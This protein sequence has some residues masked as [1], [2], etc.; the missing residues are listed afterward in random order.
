MGDDVSAVG[1]PR[2]P[3]SPGMGGRVGL[4]GVF[5]KQHW[6]QGQGVELVEARLRTRSGSLTSS[7]ACLIKDMKIKSLEE[8]SLFSLPI[9]DSEII[10]F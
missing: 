4:Q 8:I 3:R 2:G 9:K 5:G 6:G 10:D 1:G 7:W